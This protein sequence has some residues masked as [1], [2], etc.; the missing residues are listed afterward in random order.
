MNKFRWTSLLLLIMTL[1]GHNVAFAAEDP[2][3][4]QDPPPEHLKCDRW[5]PPKVTD[6][7][8]CE[9]ATS[10]P[11]WYIH[12]LGY[13][14]CHAAPGLAPCAPWDCRLHY[15]KRC[16]YQMLCKPDYL[17]V[18]VFAC[19]ALVP[20][21]AAAC[22]SLNVLA[23]VACLASVGASCLGC[24][25][26]SSCEPDETYPRFWFDGDCDCRARCP[27]QVPDPK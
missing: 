7:P 19:G 27:Q 25:V 14:D 1:I 17:A 24:G 26:V 12:E 21:C 23:C 5:I 13:W 16:G 11:P 22:V 8:P 18:A 6:C 20:V 9:G 2:K 10:C 3:E 4:H 15:R